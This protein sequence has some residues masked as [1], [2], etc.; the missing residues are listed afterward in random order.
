MSLEE[1]HMAEAAARRG[2]ALEP[3]MP[4]PDF[5]LHPTPGQLLSL[6]ELRERPVI[7]ARYPADGSPVSGDELARCNGVLSDSRRRSPRV[8]RGMLR[9]SRRM[10]RTSYAFYDCPHDREGA[11]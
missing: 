4:A 6:H 7:L 11:P 1:A 3:G 5:T 9:A 2:A 8:R 10:A